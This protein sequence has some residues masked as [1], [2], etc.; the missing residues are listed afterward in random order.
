VHSG[1]A[2]TTEVTLSSTPIAAAVAEYI[3]ASISDL[4]VLV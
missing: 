4:C 3:Q 1:V 2:C